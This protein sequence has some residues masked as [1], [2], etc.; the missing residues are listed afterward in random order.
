MCVVETRFSFANPETGFAQR[1]IYEAE[2]EVK[3]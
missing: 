1:R 2:A 3:D